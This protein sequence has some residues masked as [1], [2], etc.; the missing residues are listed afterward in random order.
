MP[1]IRIEDSIAFSFEGSLTWRIPDQKTCFQKPLPQMR[2]LG[3]PL[4]MREARDS[5][6]PMLHQRCMRHKHH[7]RRT[8]ARVQQAHIGNPQQLLV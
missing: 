6:Q 7:I 8:L 1:A 2:L 3:L 5:C 4:G